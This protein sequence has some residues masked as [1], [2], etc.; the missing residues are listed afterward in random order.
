MNTIKNIKNIRKI[1]NYTVCVAIAVIISVFFTASILIN[2]GMQIKLPMGKPHEFKVQWTDADTGEVIDRSRPFVIK[3]GKERK[4]R[5]QIKDPG[6]S[7]GMYIAFWTGYMDY[8]ITI[9]RQRVL[10]SDASSYRFG[11]ESSEH[12]AIFKINKNPSGK[13][14]QMNLTNPM[15]LDQRFFLKYM[16]AGSAADIREFVLVLNFQKMFFVVLLDLLGILLL[17]YTGLMRLY[18][19]KSQ[20]KKP[21]FYLGLLCFAAS[22]WVFIDSPF[23]QYISGNLTMRYQIF[24]GAMAI[25]PMLLLLMFR[26]VVKEGRRALNL[27][28]IAYNVWILILMGA[29]IGG[30]IPLEVGMHGTFVMLGI[31]AAVMIYYLL[32]DYRHNGDKHSIVTI[33]AFLSMA[34]GAGVDVLR[35]LILGNTMDSTIGFRHGFTLAIL[36][37]IAVLSREAVSSLREAQR[38]R[39]YK[40]RAYVDQ[41]TK[42]YTRLYLDDRIKKVPTT[43]RYFVFATLDAYSHLLLSLGEARG[44]KLLRDIYRHMETTLNE[45]EYMCY[46]GDSNFGFYMLADSIND[47]H[48]KCFRLQTQV[49]M[50]LNDN[51]VIS[52]A[53]IRFGVYN[54]SVKGK[55]LEDM[56][57]R[58]LEALKDATPS[59]F[60]D[61]NLH[62]YDQE[63][64]NRLK[65]EHYLENHVDQA[66]RDKNITFYLQPKVRLSDGQIHG[67]EALARW[68]SEETG[69]IK[70]DQFIPVF[71]RNGMIQKIDLC[72]FRQV[73]EQIAEWM[74]EEDVEVPVISVNIS[75]AAINY[76]GFFAP[77][78]KIMKETKVPGRYLEF[79]LTENIA[80]ENIELLRQLIDDIH[81]TGAKCS[82]DDFGKSYSNLSVF[83]TLSF[84]TAKMDMCFF[85]RGFP[86]E[87]EQ[88]LLVTGTLNLLQRLGLN[89]VA[90][91]I[92]T[93]EQVD[94][95]K[96][97]HCDMVQ[98]FYFG[99]PMTCA[100]FR[101]LQREK[102]KE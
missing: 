82:M 46:M 77:Y 1:S 95:L 74:K 100:E 42:G 64:Q 21:P 93:K 92:E 57:I 96:A 86:E 66:I 5:C 28:L 26:D 4:I 9:N 11:H 51:K 33:A 16:A 87:D 67:G 13:V 12:W 43:R 40:D 56:V 99:K 17:V 69:F 70:P 53:R 47:I 101:Q 22:V 15:D 48:K 14:L 31:I 3:A 61:I 24:F 75:K 89:V 88:N 72:I 60:T 41:V 65:L 97:L 7:Q 49:E 19:V 80:Y 91:G 73:C 81:R 35:Y 23:P 58:A 63:A 20:S 98:G 27:L 30:G 18:R 54:N 94:R 36:I 34:M 55:A 38:A 85:D 29:Y 62:E 71:E 102:S 37:L 10:Q 76:A 44:T 39:T 32:R 59:R 90:E 68:I 8:D 78:R 25:I 83:G 84:D 50:A 45:N 2:K 6:I 52:A 79:E